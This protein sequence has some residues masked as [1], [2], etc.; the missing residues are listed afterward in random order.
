MPEGDTVWLSAH[1]MHQALAGRTLVR[2]DLRVPKLATVD[3]RGHAVES[4]QARGKHL[5]TRFDHGWTLHSHLRMEGAW[6]IYPAGQGWRGGPSHQIRAVLANAAYAAVGYRLPILELLRSADE[7]RAVGHLGPDLL[8]DDWDPAEAV[9]RLLGDRDRPIGEAL[10]DQKNLAGVGNVYKSE[11]CF[12]AGVSPWTPVG[13]VPNLARLVTQAQRLLE[14]NKERTSRVTTGDTR[15]G[16]NLWVYGR[17]RASCARCGTPVRHVE[18]AHR[19]VPGE[20][21]VTYWCPSCQ[22]GPTP[23][24]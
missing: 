1:R 19:G 20:E 14:F 3:L 15:P 18:G 17:R 22:P 8:G 23:R 2:T 6:Q 7:Q 11:L 9:R 16:R 21:R 24:G 4:V 10:L 12:L 5:L 13:D